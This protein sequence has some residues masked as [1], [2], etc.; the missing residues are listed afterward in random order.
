V[1]K[2]KKFARI[3]V[4]RAVILDCANRPFFCA[5]GQAHIT[6]Q[7]YW[8]NNMRTARICLIAIT[9]AL[10]TQTVTASAANAEW[11]R[12][13]LPRPAEPYQGVANRTL[14]GSKPSFT[15]PVKTPS[16]APN[17]LLVL[18]DD[19]GFGNPSTF[20]GSIA[21]PTLDKLAAE[22]LRYNRYLERFAKAVAN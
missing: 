6:S 4:A 13:V 21:T 7:F 19:A 1:G 18:I 20:G 8:R 22:G 11:D 17:I 15:E 9:S 3:E 14:E 2:K 12:T 16:G 10:A 5:C